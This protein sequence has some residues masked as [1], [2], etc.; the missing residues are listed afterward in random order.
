MKTDTKEKRDSKVLP[1]VDIE[2]SDRVQIDDLLG[3]LGNHVL[4]ET[5]VVINRTSKKLQWPLRKIFVE[6]GKDLEVQDWEIVLLVLEF[7]SSFSSANKYLRV[8]YKELDK[9]AATFDED[10][11]TVFQRLIYFDV[12]TI[13]TLSGN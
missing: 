1:G 8:L 3:T 13:N 10:S 9:L 7:E 4:A 11:R 6:I 12:K 5:V 2:Y